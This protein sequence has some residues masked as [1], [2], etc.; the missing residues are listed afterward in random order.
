ML[1]KALEKQMNGEGFCLVE[2][3]SSCPT[4]WNL[5]PDESIAFM[6]EQQEKTFALGEFRNG[7]NK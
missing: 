7:G 6:K 4:N 1:K 3:L 2:V 5:Q